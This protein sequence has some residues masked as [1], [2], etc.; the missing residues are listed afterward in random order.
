[1]FSVRSTI[2]NSPQARRGLFRNFWRAWFA[3]PV[4]VSLIAFIYSFVERYTASAPDIDGFL[5]AGPRPR[6]QPSFGTTRPPNEPI[7]TAEGRHSIESWSCAIRPIIELSQDPTPRPP[8]TPN[9]FTIYAGDNNPCNAAV[10]DGAVTEIS[11][12]V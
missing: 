5:A 8:P 1:M 4:L 7:F 2:L 3:V 12:N 10:S 6:P 11:G 9:G